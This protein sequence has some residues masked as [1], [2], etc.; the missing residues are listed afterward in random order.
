MSPC[1]A[2]LDGENETAYEGFHTVLFSQSCAPAAGILEPKSL[3]LCPREGSVLLATVIGWGQLGKSVP[4]MNT[5]VGPRGQQVGAGECARISRRSERHMFIASVPLYDFY[6]A[7]KVVIKKT[8]TKKNRSSPIDLWQFCFPCRIVW[9]TYGALPSDPTHL[10]ST[11]HIIW[12][13]RTS[14]LCH[15]HQAMWFL[16]PHLPFLSQPPSEI[17]FP[18]EIF[19]PGTLK[20]QF[21]QETLFE[22]IC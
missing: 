4:S 15:W 16:F 19:R 7:T 14:L 20:V 13:A 11:I 8:K 22:G 6:L 3:S 9:V 18:L 17:L 5:A 2:D 1:R 10:S 21:T 12:L